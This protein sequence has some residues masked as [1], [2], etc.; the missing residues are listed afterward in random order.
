MKLSSKKTYTLYFLVILVLLVCGFFVFKKNNLNFNQDPAPEQLVNRRLS[1]IVVQTVS[2]RPTVPLAIAN[3]SS[4]QNCTQQR[5]DLKALSLKDYVENLKSGKTHFD[6]TCYPPGLEQGQKIDPQV[7]SSY[8]SQ[9]KLQSEE[10]LCYSTL[11]WYRS[12]LLWEDL[13]TLPLHTL[14]P[15]ELVVGFFALVAKSQDS[16]VLPQLKELVKELKNRMPLSPFVA[17]ASLMPYLLEISKTREGLR[18]DLE[19][20]EEEFTDAR[21]LNPQDLEIVEF[22]LIKGIQTKDPNLL[23]KVSSFNNEFPQSGVALYYLGSYHWKANRRTEALEALDQAILREPNNLRY[24]RTRSALEEA[25]L[26][27]RAFEIQFS[28]DPTEI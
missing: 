3:A 5:E 12:L 24:R 11:L 8:C 1:E 15:E 14:K 25:K 21:Q 26:G 4:S 18:P 27:E 22:E 13:K 19:G 9:N 20:F 10:K 7:A 23:Q 2:R 16:S 28:F 17:K 6:P